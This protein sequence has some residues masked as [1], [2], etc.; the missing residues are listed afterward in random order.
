MERLFHRIF[1]AT[2]F[3]EPAEHAWQVA[4]NLA[5][6]HRAEVVLVHAFVEMPT[7]PEVATGQVHTVWEE[8]RRWV[9]QALD[10]R[11]AAAEARG[12]GARG[13]LVTGPPAEAVVDAAAR[14][15]AD[16]LVVGTH[17]RTGLERVLI[18]SVAERIVRAAP[19]PVLVVRPT[20][21]RRGSAGAA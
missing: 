4:E 12:V 9:Q 16:L 17:G 1:C 14:D 5:S 20:K 11:A 3:S 2:D 18:G 8:Q 13:L 10:Q 6:V 21:S 19:C 15:G 7:Y